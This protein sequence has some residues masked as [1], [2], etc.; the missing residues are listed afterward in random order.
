MEPP[1]MIY[2]VVSSYGRA[3]FA[4]ESFERCIERVAALMRSDADDCVSNPT[5]YRIE[6][7]EAE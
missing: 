2:V 1:K 6:K 7:V 3:C 5:M 4:N